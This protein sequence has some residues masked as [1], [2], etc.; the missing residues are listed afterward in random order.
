MNN[1]WNKKNQHDKEPSIKSLHLKMEKKDDIYI[2]WALL[3]SRFFRERKYSFTVKMCCSKVAFQ[4]KDHDYSLR[5]FSGI[6][7][8]N[9]CGDLPVFS[10]PVLVQQW[11]KRRKKITLHSAA[12]FYYWITHKLS[13]DSAVLTAWQIASQLRSFVCFYSAACCKLN[14]LICWNPHS[15]LF[16]FTTKESTLIA[17]SVD[18]N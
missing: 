11:T 17:G 6:L 10:A 3:F 15:F 1:V 9:Y 14:M 13:W 4:W 12:E 7:K 5:F 2:D 16:R 18:E 8:Y